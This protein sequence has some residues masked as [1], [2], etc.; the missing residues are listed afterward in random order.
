MTEYKVINTITGYSLES[1]QKFRKALTKVIKLNKKY[2]KGKFTV[3][4]T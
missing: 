4:R 2:G 1:F 3:K